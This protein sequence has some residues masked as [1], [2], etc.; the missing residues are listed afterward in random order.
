M[1][2]G[3]VLEYFIDMSTQKNR[4]PYELLAKAFENK[5]AK[6]PSYSQAAL[7]RDLGVS[8]VFVSKVFTGEKDVPPARFKKLFK[9][10]E[11]DINLQSVFI[12]ATLLNSLPSE[13]LKDLV[14]SNFLTE[15]KMEN[16]K[17][18]SPKKISLLQ[19]WYH[20]P[21]L[22]YLTCENIDLSPKAIAKY[23]KV[24][25]IEIVQS[26]ESLQTLGLVENQNGF[27]KKVEDHSYFPTTQTKTEVRDF[28]KQMIQKAYQELSKADAQAFEKRLITG[29]SIAANPENVEKSKKLIFDFLSEISHSLSEGSCSEVYQCN[30]QLFP[31]GGTR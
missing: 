13:D 23:F 28:H 5:K 11:M 27:W 29:F 24:T 20:V 15:N 12:K 30:V 18:E 10:L 26:L 6:N 8:S 21:L 17:I 9:V 4:R 1:S 25:E 19:K 7:A 31:F 14:R 16:Y 3:I 2:T 22:T